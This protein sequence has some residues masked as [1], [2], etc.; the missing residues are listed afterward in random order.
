MFALTTKNG[1]T[2]IYLT[3][4][5]RTRRAS[6]GPFAS[7]FWRTDN[8]DQPAAT[9]L[10]DAGRRRAPLR[11]GEHPFPATYNG[12][13]KLTSNT[14][15]SPYY[16]TIDFCTAQC[17]YD[18]NVYTPAG[19]PDT[20]YVI[21]SFTTASI[22][23]NT[24]GVGCGNGRSNGRAVIYSTRPGDPDAARRDDANRT[25]TDLTF[26]AQNHPGDW[27]ALGNAQFTSAA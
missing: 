4:G 9:L 12:W 20:V 21:G 10:G 13:Q 5:T 16:A 3:E 19:M 23:C 22:P 8:G 27:C 6:A 2:R 17:W 1:H 11:P 26:D 14:T 15:A 18:Q 7:N 25:F 24:K